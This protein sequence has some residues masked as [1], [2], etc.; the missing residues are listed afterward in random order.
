MTSATSLMSVPN[1]LI[2]LYQTGGRDELARGIADW[3]TTH[4]PG[5]I[6]AHAIETATL[7]IDSVAV[8]LTVTEREDLF[9]ARG[10]GERD[11]L[12]TMLESL[13]PTD[14]VW[15][16]GANVGTY[17]LLAAQVGATVHAFE[18]GDDARRRLERNAARNGLSPTIH[19]VALSDT[20][21]MATLAAADRS[22]VRELTDGGD[23]D[24]V[25]TRRGD[26]VDASAP[27]IVKIDVEG[28][29][30]AVLDGLGDRFETCR[31]CFVEVHDAADERAVRDRLERRGF[32]VTAPFERSI[33]QAK[34]G[35]EP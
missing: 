17:A 31:L 33:L 21:G 1:R 30:L 2:D 25:R 4:P 26:R 27:D 19:G 22:G 14:T 35:G 32:D 18:P 34:R 23:G 11:A 24:R 8:E 15:D 13:D 12:A 5:H 10:H 29:E 7:S 6:V 28:A 9:R 20:D 3:I 16:V